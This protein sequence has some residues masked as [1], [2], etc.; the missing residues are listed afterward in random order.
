[1]A[2]FSHGTV[3]RLRGKAYGLALVLG[4]SMA[5]TTAVAVDNEQLFAPF[6]T[7]LQQSVD[8]GQVDYDAF[9]QSDDFAEMITTI[10]RTD[11]PKNA[12]Q[13]QR[14]AT[15][16]N[17]Y[18]ALSIQG[19]LDG[20]S[21]SSI[22]S[23]LKFFKRRQYD[24]FGT[25]MTLYELEHQRI[26]KEGDPRIHFAIV[27]SSQSCPSLINELYLPATLNK[28]L[29]EV[30]IA[31]VNNP[32]SNRFDIDT[33]RAEISRIFKWYEDEFA[34]QD[35]SLAKFLARYT[36]DPALR[37]S[38]SNDDW[39]FDFVAYDWSLNGTFKQ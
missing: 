39:N 5:C 33:R 29:D 26:I 9:K 21:P 18:N 34:A 8:N 35:G 22:F 31:F 30:T 28:Q 12:S 16:I 32:D 4:G 15:Y 10:G 1:M 27:C 36:Q 6:A 17:T 23:R 25:S 7:L 38:L 13:A 20:F 19:I 14:L 11:T 2:N 3:K 24:V 37:E